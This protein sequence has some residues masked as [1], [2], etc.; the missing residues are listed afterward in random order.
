MGTG[1]NAL[2]LLKNTV[3]ATRTLKK[4]NK[5]AKDKESVKYFI[6]WHHKLL[7]DS[8]TSVG[9]SFDLIT[10]MTTNLR[11]IEKQLE[12][13]AGHII[14]HEQGLLLKAKEQKT[15]S[16]EKA[17]FFCLTNFNEANLLQF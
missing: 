12:I 17:V 11:Q 1:N 8:V 6:G 9:D 14:A 5:S 7:E 13:H 2:Q 3:R 15:D 16:P 10:N 4:T